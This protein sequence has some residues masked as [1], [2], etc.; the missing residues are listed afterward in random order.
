M[1]AYTRLSVVRTR[2]CEWEGGGG[3]SG[4]EVLLSSVLC[5]FP[6]RELG[7]GCKMFRQQAHQPFRT[8]QEIPDM[9]VVNGNGG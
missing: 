2:G 4:V 8:I 7:E 9:S 1:D 3:V 5:E 6:P